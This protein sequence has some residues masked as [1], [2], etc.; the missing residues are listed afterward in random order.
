VLGLL[1]EKDLQTYLGGANRDT[2]AIAMVETRAAL[3]VLD[4]I[5]AIEGID[6]IFVGPSDF[7]IAL[8]DGAR[9]DPFEAD[10]LKTAADVAARTTRAGKVACT[11]GTTGEAAAQFRSLGFR[12]IAIGND[13]NYLAKG[14]A[15]LLEAA[16]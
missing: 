13:F 14:A 10:M 15:A 3:A 12:F 4:D 5:L 11:L 6:G 9:I 8:S 7:S 2:L 16:R 1:G